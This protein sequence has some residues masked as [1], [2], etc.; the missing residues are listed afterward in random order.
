MSAIATT[1]SPL[2]F[3]AAGRARAEAASASAFKFT[4]VAAGVDKT[5]HVAEGYDAKILLRWG[6][7]VLPGAPVLDPM[8][9]TA[10][11]QAQQFGYNNDYIGFIPFDA[12]G[13]RGLL[14]VNH[15]Y[16]D[17]HL[18]FPGVASVEKTGEGADAKEEVV[19]AP[20]SK[21]QV[22]VEMAGHG[23]T[24]I[25][26]VR[27]ADGWKAVTDSPLNRR[28]TVSTEMELTG[29]AAGH[30][31]MTTTEDPAG[32]RVLGT[33]KKLRRRRNALGHLSDGRGELSRLLHRRRRRDGR[34]PPRVRQL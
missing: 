21:E 9:Q 27:D 24:I 31:R 30:A 2:A 34:I 19:I 13:N 15:E 17:P 20:L 10:D 6:D 28:I 11:A 22:D 16:T 25:E 33:L 8:N 32:T 5:H 7:P 18:M 23:G 29:P 4:E 14:V 1:V 3:I 12:E 26:I